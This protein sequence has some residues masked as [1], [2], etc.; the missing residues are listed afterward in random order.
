MDPSAETALAPTTASAGSSARVTPRSSDMDAE[1]ERRLVQRAMR[2]SV[3]VWPS[4]TALDAFM[5]FVVYPDAPFGRFV[6]YRLVVELLLFSGF[7]LSFRPG[8]ALAWL[9]VIQEVTFFAAAVFVSIM[10][11]DLGGLH[12]PYVHGLSVVVLVH[13]VVIHKPWTAGIRILLPIALSY[14]VVMAIAAALDPALRAA[15]WTAPSLAAFAS[16]YVFVISS[17]AIGAVAGELVWTAQKQLYQARR[18]GRYRLEFPIGRGGM[19]EVWLAWD[20]ALRQKVA[21]KI[22]RA[23]GKAEPAALRRFEREAHAASGLRSPHTIRTLDFGTTDDGIYYIAMEYL[24]GSDLGDLVEKHG[25]LPAARVARFGLQICESLVEAHEAGIIHRDIKPQNLY[26]TT[27]GDDRDF[28]KLLDFGIARVNASA[29]ETQVTQV[30]MVAGTPGYMAPE[31]WR[32]VEPDARTDIYGV[33][34]TLYVLLTGQLPFDDLRE[35]AFAMKAAAPPS[36]RVEEPIPAELEAAVL[37]CLA[38]LPEDR[39]VNMRALQAALA[40]AAAAQQEGW[41][42][43]DARLFWEAARAGSDDAARD[44]SGN[45]GIRVISDPAATPSSVT[46]IASPKTST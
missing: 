8:V 23:E 24:P 17:T 37:R 46:L 28:L 10:A 44:A 19:S 36:S 2:I 43:D 16:H 7:V 9:S 18:L 27:V 45:R 26:V 35:G 40:V 14:P 31:L 3:W 39:F 15:W 30:G 1:R 38:P 41:T 22:L 12:S 13:S 6:V 32:G 29:G 11:L 34:A 5:C 33:G 25:A 20:A 42:I 4:F 21:L